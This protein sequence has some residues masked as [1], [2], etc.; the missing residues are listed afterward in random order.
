M[1]VSCNIKNLFVWPGFATF[2][3][4]IMS[5]AFWKWF[6]FVILCFIWGSSFKLMRDGTASMTAAQV[7]ALRI[8][9]AGLVFVPFAFFH[10]RTI[11]KKKLGIVIL[12]AVVGNLIPAFLF[13]A[14]LTKIDGS[15][16]GI[17]N[18]LT[19]ICVVITGILLYRDKIKTQKI[20]GVII[21]FAGLA[22]LILSPV[23]TGEKSI[24]FENPGHLLL[25]VAAT[26]LYGINVN[27]VSHLLKGMNP[28]HVA[29]V[30]LS[31]MTIPSLLALWQQNF[32]DLNFK[33]SETQY[34][35]FA[36]IILGIF[37]SAIATVLFYMLVRRAG[38][39]FA[40]LVTYGIPFVALFWGVI[41]NEKIGLLQIICLFIIL[42]GVYLANRPEKNNRANTG[43]VQ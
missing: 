5:N 40:S 37:G 27:M 39:L 10:L 24:S 20:L 15:L 35:V 7:A 23:I 8:F 11:P 4:I 18:S 41:D 38:G 42:S 16:G 31:F 14:A 2:A 17:L 9:S 26:F 3:S 29:T 25:I 1:F 30:S 32:L 13:A 43:T 34:A 12:S 33:S 28:V 21:G 19:P 22:L 6:L 36:V